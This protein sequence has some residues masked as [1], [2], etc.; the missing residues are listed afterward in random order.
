[1]ARG[2]GPGLPGGYQPNK[3]LDILHPPRGQDMARPVPP[4][5]R[6]TTSRLDDLLRIQEEVESLKKERD[7]LLAAKEKEMR[8]VG[9]FGHGQKW[10]GHYV[11]I[12]AYDEQSARIMM[13]EK[14]GQEWSMLYHSSTNQTAEDAAGVQ[15]WGYKLLTNDM[16]R[17]AAIEAAKPFNV[18]EG[19][20]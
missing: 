10:A 17:E 7:A 3:P 5:P 4:P 11:V 12:T 9:T 14:F 6:F 16:I 18:I 15:R 20:L 19:V 8:Y 2:I 13:Q 1:M